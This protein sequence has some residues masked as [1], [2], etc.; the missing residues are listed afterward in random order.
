MHFYTSDTHFGH[1]NIIKF[2]N[3]PFKD[4]DHM[5]EIIIANWNKVVSPD[6]VVWH[7]GDV[8]MGQIDHTLPL[9]RRLNGYK[10]LVPGNHDRIFSGESPAKIEKF[11]GRYDEVFSLVTDE[12][13]WTSIDG[14]T[15]MMCHFPYDG[16]S[17]ER[18]RYSEIRPVESGIPLIHG[19][20]HSAERVSRSEHGTLQI[21]VGVDA[22]DFRPVS[23][24]EII[25]LFK[26]NK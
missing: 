23:D 26:E 20:T 15:F 11:I 3:R 6:D 17:Q 5:N 19:H 1:K 22:W 9:V 8:A 4:V 2:C 24:L 18:D 12:Q 7:L 10:I 25:N 13:K 16:D 14:T 21:H